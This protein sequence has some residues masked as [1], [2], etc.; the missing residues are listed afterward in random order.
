MKNIP[1]PLCVSSLI[2]LSVVNSYVINTHLSGHEIRRKNSLT[3]SSSFLFDAK[4]W[5]HNIKLHNKFSDGFLEEEV[6]RLKSMAAKLRSE[7]ATL[8]AEIADEI[9]ANI[10]KEFSRFD[11]DNSGTVSIEELKIGLEKTLKL[12]LSDETISKLIE[13]FDHSGDGVLQPDEF[14]PIE[15]FRNRIDE[16]AREE[17]TLAAKMKKEALAEAE[18]VKAMEA[19]IEQL[20]DKAPTNREKIISTLPYLFPLLESLQYSEFILKGEL[21]NNPLVALLGTVHG[22]YRSIPPSGFIVFIVLRIL[23][24]NLKINRLIR[25]NMKQ[26]IFLYIALIFPALLLEIGGLALKALDMSFTSQV[27]E[28]NSDIVFTA[29]ILILSYCV[30]STLLGITPDKV[31]VVS[32]AVNDRMPTIEIFNEKSRF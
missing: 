28:V 32:K 2:L 26:A 16:L 30:I 21:L 29:S 23:S 8:E 27:F 19:V 5:R 17:K 14:V 3:T 31:P 18:A 13:T 9:A 11:L 10:N 15:K 4:N 1:L 25:Y 6:I 20:N 24:R 22:L 7:A 12:E